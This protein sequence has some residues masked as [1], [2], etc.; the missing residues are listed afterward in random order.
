VAKPARSLGLT[1]RDAGVE[2][3]DHR[4]ERSGGMHHEAPGGGVGRRQPQLPGL[5]DGEHGVRVSEAR[6]DL[7]AHAFHLQERLMLDAVRR[8]P[9]TG[10]APARARPGRPTGQVP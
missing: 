6:L 8:R 1:A 4:V 7:Y 10:Q 9:A 5:G 3:A 2:L